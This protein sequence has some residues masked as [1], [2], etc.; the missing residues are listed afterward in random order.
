MGV[1]SEK[2]LMKTTKGFTH[3]H[4]ENPQKAS[5]KTFV[6]DSAESLYMYYIPLP[7]MFIKR[8]AST[9]FYFTLMALVDGYIL[10]I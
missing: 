5:M 9:K 2:V 1:F 10:L 6:F 4:N 7:D 3:G 8:I